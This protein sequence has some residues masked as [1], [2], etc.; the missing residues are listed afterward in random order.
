[1]TDEARRA[2]AR[3]PVTRHAA[4]HGG[5]S[6]EDEVAVE[7]PLEIRLAGE[8]LAVTMR[9]PGHDRELALGF[10]L[11]EGVITSLSDVG[12]ASHCGRPG[13][14]G[15]G[16]TIDVQPGPGAVLEVAEHPA[17][18]RGT[19]TT[20]ACGVCG[21]RSIEDL[22]VRI[23]GPRPGAPLPLPL[24]ARSTEL[25]AAGQSGFER[26]GGMHAA[27]A[28]SRAGAARVTHEDVGRH[29]AVD[30][31]VGS[32]LLSGALPLPPAS[33]AEADAPA[34]LAVSGRVSFEIVQ[35]AAMAGFVAVCGISAPTSL[36]VDL[37][38]SAGITLAAFVRDGRLNVY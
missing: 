13:D 27:T 36:A 2:T 10:L 20:S 30:K 23:P 15:Y 16:H 28:V 18:R 33:D 17:L 34:V 12:G 11:A 32:L 8:P 37:A 14:E 21:R 29:N 24:L 26:T 5:E 4:D 31:V 19:L 7:A 3:R 9:T 6:A 1:M 25:L 22:L 38:Q 35:K